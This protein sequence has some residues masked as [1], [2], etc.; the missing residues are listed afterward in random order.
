MHLLLHLF[1]GRCSGQ[2]WHGAD[3]ES[4]PTWL[5]MKHRLCNAALTTH[6]M[7]FLGLDPAQLSLVGS[8][9]T[10]RGTLKIEDHLIRLLTQTQARNP[11]QEALT[12]ARFDG[13][14]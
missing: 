3:L 9:T 13:I 8:D 4:D 7:D 6:K 2:V 5:C 1:P 14:G 11:M 12:G 10:P